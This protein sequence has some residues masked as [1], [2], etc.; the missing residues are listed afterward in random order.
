MTDYKNCRSSDKPKGAV[1]LLIVAMAAMVAMLGH[2]DNQN[3]EIKR[4]E[5][6]CNG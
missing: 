6:T 1:V 5:I 3:R 4:L 2:I